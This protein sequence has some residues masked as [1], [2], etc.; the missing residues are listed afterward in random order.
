MAI[1]TAV[2]AA[3]SLFGS[4]RDIIG[5][6]IA[7]DIADP[8][9]L[10]GLLIGGAVPFLFSSLTIRAVGRAAGTVVLEVRRQFADNPGIMDFSVKPDYARVVDICTRTSLRELASPGLLAITTPI[11]VGFAFGALSLG[12][13]LAGAI[14]VGQLLAVYLSNAGGA[15]DNAKK[16]IEE[17]HYGGKNSPA[18]APS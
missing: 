1:A 3:T 15:W 12:A 10:I 17:G 2:L 16:Y 5:E 14:L 11:V 18:H 9:I 7:I 13:Y 8:K 4:F 6:G